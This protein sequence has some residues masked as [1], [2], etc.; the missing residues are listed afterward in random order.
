M[1]PFSGTSAVPGS[2]QAN[3][4]RAGRHV[5]GH[6]AGTEPLD[7]SCMARGKGFAFREMPC[8]DIVPARAIYTMQDTSL[9]M[10]SA[11]G[12]F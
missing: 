11:R 6:K 12:W 3:G 9:G 1:L 2:R 4:T 5:P 7:V 8:T 10:A